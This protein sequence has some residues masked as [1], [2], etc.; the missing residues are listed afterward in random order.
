MD[1]Y[2][3]TN[4]T[5]EEEEI[6]SFIEIGELE[7]GAEK[8]IYWLSED[9]IKRHVSKLFMFSEVTTIKQDLY[10]TALTNLLKKINFL[11]LHQQL[12]NNEITEEEFDNYLNHD[13]VKY[14]IQMNKSISTLEKHL[15]IQI[16][17]RIG[18]DIK[19]FSY[20]DIE[21]LFSIKY[22]NLSNTPM[23]K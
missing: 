14:T 9:Q 5:N 23:I 11:E 17:S 12:L 16:I 10:T 15:I 8:N 1:N 22:N 13:S 21:E 18:T 2:N 6:G 20:S 3:I 7:V 19:E 4:H